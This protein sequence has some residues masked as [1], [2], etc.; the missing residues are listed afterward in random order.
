MIQQN[1]RNVIK[2][3]FFTADEISSALTNGHMLN[4]S[5]DLSNPCNL[6]CPYCY[7]EEKNSLRKIRKSNE[8]TH[9]EVVQVITDLYS[10]GARTVNIVGAGEPTIDPH[11]KDTIQLISDCGLTTVLFTNGISFFHD[12]KLVRFLYKNDVSVVLKYNSLVSDIQDLVAGR[13][14]YT[15]KRNIAL[16]QLLDEGFTAHE[17][18][19]LGLDVIVFSGNFEEIPKIH[20]FCRK[21]NIFPIAGEYIPTGRTDDGAFQG[22]DS[23]NGFSENDRGRV[24]RL[25]QPIN[26]EQ[27]A[28]LSKS[29]EVIDKQF[30]IERLSNF[31][32]FGGG[33]CTQTLGLYID[34]DGNIWPCVARKQKKGI[35]FEK[36][37]LGNIRSGDKPSV[38]WRNHEYLKVVRSAFSGGCLY[39]PT[40]SVAA[41]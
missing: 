9:E 5:I 19:R 29:L 41:T 15:Q 18:T 12:P 10:C 14:G 37:L 4:P 36:G 32:Y 6:N 20:E 23:L 25:L 3:W 11:F 7:I 35:I 26:N 28:A 34:I 17:P 21:Q 38:I 24:T 2:G 1:C 27:R 22:Y 16:E 13:P 40:L 33:I 8:L 39:K 31:A 30:G